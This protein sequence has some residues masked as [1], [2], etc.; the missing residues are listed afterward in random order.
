L[1]IYAA[2]R[3]FLHMLEARYF[4]I[5]TGHKPLTFAFQHKS[6]MCSPKQFNH[7]DYISQITMDI[8]HI[9]G[10]DNIVADALSRVDPITVTG[11]PQPRTAITSSEH[12][13]CVTALQLENPLISGT[14]FELYCDTYSVK[15]RPCVPSPLCRQ[16]FD[17]H[18]HPGRKATAKL[19]SQRFVCPAI[20]KD[21]SI[22]ARASNLPAL[23]GLGMV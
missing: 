11:L 18:S 7:V 23:Q 22:W 9:S 20:Q 10:Q 15:P 1:A 14:S 12:Y 21:C 8:R 4:T 3:I 2:V 13:W 16:I 5:L 6:D 19:V 17:F